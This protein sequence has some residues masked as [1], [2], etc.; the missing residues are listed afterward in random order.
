[1]AKPT[2]GQGEQRRRLAA[3]PTAACLDDSTHRGTTPGA[4]LTGSWHT[5]RV[6]FVFEGSHRQAANL[7]C[8]VWTGKQ[9]RDL[10]R[11]QWL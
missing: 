9:F 7:Y 8:V 5:P 11:I 1:M 10:E 4:E 6:G 3:P 2:P